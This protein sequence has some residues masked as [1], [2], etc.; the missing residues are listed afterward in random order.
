[1]GEGVK[2]MVRPKTTTK[3]ETNNDKITCLKCKKEKAPNTQNFYVNTNPLLSSEKF[4]TCKDCITDYIGEKD[5]KGYLSRVKLVLAMLDKPFLSDQWE[6]R[7]RDWSK[8]I[9]PLSSFPQYKGMTYADSDFGANP[10]T[11]NRHEVQNA[12][13]SGFIG[14]VKPDNDQ[15]Y[16][17]SKWMGE[18]TKSEIDYLESYYSGL[19]G[20]FKIVTTNH[21]DYAKK[22]SKASLHMDKCFQ[23]MLA[24]VSG[25][26]KKYKEARETF[27][28]LSKSAQFSESQRG[29][30]DVSLGCFGRVFD[31]VET[32]TYIPEHIV[33]NPDDIDKMIE[34]F[35]H[36]FKSV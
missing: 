8:Y 29:Q 11:N 36:I 27:D 23:D 33:T 22:I 25:A 35:K 13:V 21:K 14:D 2:T 1:L 12:T 7:E 20:D 15:K 6:L 4:L 9:P 32:K 28:T 3:K 26:D 18:Y 16:Y 31:M 34:D 17:N 24:G 30:N 5:S 10:S 19:D